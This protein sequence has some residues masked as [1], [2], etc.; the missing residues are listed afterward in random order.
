MENSFSHQLLGSLARDVVCP[1]QRPVGL[2][3]TQ[4]GVS[5]IV[6][7]GGSQLGMALYS[8]LP[9]AFASLNTKKM[10]VFIVYL[11]DLLSV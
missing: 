7:L 5:K 2:S 9:N 3:L 6:F 11:N 10:Y 1:G 8:G 4:K